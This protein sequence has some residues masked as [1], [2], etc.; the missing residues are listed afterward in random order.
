MQA[1][2]G[3]QQLDF[4]DGDEPETAAQLRDGKESLPAIPAQ[5]VSA[6]VAPASP[7]SPAAAFS[8]PKT[9]KAVRFASDGHLCDYLDPARFSLPPDPYALL[10]AFD[11][12]LPTRPFRKGN[13][14][15]KYRQQGP[16]AAAAAAA[17]GDELFFSASGVYTA[18]SAEIARGSVRVPCHAEFGDL[19]MRELQRRKRQERSR[20]KREREEAVSAAR[21]D[22]R[23]VQQ[24]AVPQPPAVDD[25]RDDDGD[26]FDVLQPAD[27]DADVDEWSQPSLLPS[28]LSS[29]SAL[30]G[31]L[32]GLGRSYE[33][34]CREHLD[35]Y[36][37]S[38]DEYLHSTAMTQRV[39]EWQ[40]KL[41]PILEEEDAHPEFDIRLYGDR[42]IHRVGEE[43][44]QQHTD[45]Q[46]PAS[47][48]RGS[49]LAHAS[50]SHRGCCL[51][52]IVLCCP[53]LRCA[54]V[55]FETVVRGAARYEVCRLFL[56]ALQLVS[57]SQQRTAAAGRRRCCSAAIH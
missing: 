1:E 57:S 28:L 18:I 50:V 22:S 19:F 42:M 56:A 5:P 24:L 8:S 27:E 13:N 4:D 45:G 44:K 41:E 43:E 34:L 9:A 7:S 48:S 3:H 26:A 36:L 55:E 31:E 33:D 16:A 47:A 37:H 14:V 20:R 38:A 39:R 21:R 52:A 23:A 17:G 15:R 51:T 25:G 53:V 6:A 40:E 49:C 29:S 10:D 2:L 11:S 54:V 46:Q 35:A 12:S 32:S 30:D